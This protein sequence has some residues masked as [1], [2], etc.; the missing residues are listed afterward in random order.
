[1]NKIDEKF[2]VSIHNYNLG[3]TLYCLCKNGEHAKE[4]HYW[5]EYGGVFLN[6][7]KIKNGRIIEEYAQ[8]IGGPWKKQKRGFL[9]KV[10]LRK[11]EESQIFTEK[12]FLK[13]KK[14]GKKEPTIKYQEFMGWFDQDEVEEDDF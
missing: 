8:S 4:L 9:D 13:M 14:N 3:I 1:M 7:V 10:F 6:I 11:V 2:A 5:L 12:F